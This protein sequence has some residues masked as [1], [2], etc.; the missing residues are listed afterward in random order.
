M[1]PSS[2]WGDM[3]AAL[4]QRCALVMRTRSLGLM[5][6]WHSSGFSRLTRNHCALRCSGAAY[7]SGGTGS[8]GF[9]YTLGRVT[10]MLKKFSLAGNTLTLAA[11]A[12]AVGNFST[13]GGA[14]IPLTACC[15]R[16]AFDPSWQHTAPAVA[17]HCSASYA[18]K[19]VMVTNGSQS[20]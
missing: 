13:Y 7:W 3:Y 20:C 5:S 11:V 6:C 2:Y 4:H 18:A 19:E 16:C 10:G 14:L 8:P 12:G 15:A 9:V 1:V 17:V